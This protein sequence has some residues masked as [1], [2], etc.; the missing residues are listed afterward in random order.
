[1]LGVRGKEKEEISKDARIKA[2]FMLFS[3]PEWVVN[4]SCSFKGSPSSGLGLK[5]RKGRVPQDEKMRGDLMLFV[6]PE[7]IGNGRRGSTG[8]HYEP[9]VTKYI[10]YKDSHYSGSKVLKGARF[11]DETPSYLYG[12][13]GNG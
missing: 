10:G 11:T 2:C 6:V 4:R 12:D 5:S 13:L 8:H 3:V 1:V 7:Q 9:S